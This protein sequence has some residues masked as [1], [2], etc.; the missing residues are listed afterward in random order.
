MDDEFKFKLELLKY[1]MDTVQSGIRAYSQV[2]FTIKGWAITIFSGF[3]FFAAKEKQPIFLS[4]SAIAVIL[5]WILD[6]IF[7]SIQE[8]YICRATKIEH[9]LQKLEF[10]PDKHPFQNFTV[11]NTESAFE[12]LKGMAKAK[13]T[14]QAGLMPQLA[15]LYVVMLAVIAVLGIA[16]INIL[17]SVG[18]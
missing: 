6:A 9:F 18:H 12:Q 10:L 14:L 11:P 17:Q 1:E 16:G 8:V 13:A 7:K 4:L 5:F 2:Q 15:L 3:I